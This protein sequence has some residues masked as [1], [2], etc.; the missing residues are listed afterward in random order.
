M[1]DRNNLLNFSFI[2][3][4]SP[5][6]Q[7]QQL[8]AYA[9]YMSIWLIL[10]RFPLLGWIR[11]GQRCV[12]TSTPLS[13]VNFSANLFLNYKVNTFVIQFFQIL[14][15]SYY[16]VNHVIETSL[17]FSNTLP[18]PQCGILSDNKSVSD[19]DNRRLNI[20]EVKK[21]EQLQKK[22]Y[23]LTEISFNELEIKSKNEIT[24]TLFETV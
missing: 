1:R 14:S 12:S 18:M 13:L 10:Q 6:R 5:T 3:L 9:D 11:V 4:A 15:R 20:I 2:Q 23:T 19:K 17:A 16:S 22:K 24:S 7:I 21:L 8:M